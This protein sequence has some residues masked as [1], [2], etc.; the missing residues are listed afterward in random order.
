MLP[1]SAPKTGFGFETAE[2]A[3]RVPA[4]VPTTLQ[5]LVRPEANVI[6]PKLRLEQ[7]ERE[8]DS[9]RTIE[10]PARV[11]DAVMPRQPDLKYLAHVREVETSNKETWSLLKEGKFSVV[12]CNRFPETQPKAGGEKD[13]GVVNTVLLRT[14][15]RGNP[16]FRE[17]L[18]RVRETT[19]AAY[20][21]Q[22]LPFETLVQTLERERH[23]QRRSLCQVMFIL[24][25]AI[26]HPPQFS[27]L[28]LSLIGADE[29]AGEP[30]LTAT[31]CDIVLNVWDKPHGL[32]GVCI[33]KT[34]L[35]DAATVNQMLEDFQRVLEAI[36]VQ[37]E[38][39]LST[40]SA[41]LVKASS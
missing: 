14:D 32:A 12:V 40:F 9:C 29:S 16:T 4:I 17:V 21:H 7:Y 2:E 11:F 23:L 8:E 13:W 20:A 41:H 22:E 37:P 10:L 19:L 38:Q 33:Y 25:N 28:K 15:L 39:P 34:T 36:V 6:G 3:R 30:G 18:R 1:P 27:D 35:F 24:Q 5:K 26:W 31:T